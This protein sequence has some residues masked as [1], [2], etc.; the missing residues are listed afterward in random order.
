MLSFDGKSKFGDYFQA[1]NASGLKMQI[2][3]IRWDNF[4]LNL[5]DRKRRTHT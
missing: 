5:I 1:F 2:T 3:D 4:E